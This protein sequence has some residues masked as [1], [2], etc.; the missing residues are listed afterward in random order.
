[1]ERNGID[2]EAGVRSIKVALTTTCEKLVD[3]RRTPIGQTHT[4]LPLNQQ[5]KRQSD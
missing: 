5:T 4:L 2:A 3:V 1:M